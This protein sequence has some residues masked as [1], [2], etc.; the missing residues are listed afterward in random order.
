[1]E[2]LNPYRNEFASLFFS[3]LDGIIIIDTE[4]AK[5]TE[6]NNAALRILKY[7]R[8]ELV[9]NEYFKILVHEEQFNPEV[10]LENF[11]D[12]NYILNSHEFICQDGSSAFAD[13]SFSMIESNHKIFIVLTLRSATKRD[14]IGI[15]PL[16]DII[17]NGTDSKDC[18][19]TEAILKENECFHRLVG[20][21]NIMKDLFREIENISKFD[22]SILIYGETGTG[23]ELV[24]TAIHQQSKR[25]ENPFIIINC[26]GLSESL[27]SSQLFGHK[28]GSFTG[29]VNNQ[30]GLIEAAN[31]GTCF[32]DEIG[33]VPMA[34]QSHL[35]RVLQEKEI[36]MIGDSKSKKIDA[37][38]LAATNRDLKKE[39]DKDNFRLDLFYRIQTATI[40]VPPL[41]ERKEDI[42]Y[43]VAKF[44][45][46]FY[47]NQDK[48]EHRI[49]ND[50]IEA[51]QAHDWPGNV[52]ELKGSI[53]YALI[54]ANSQI[55]RAKDLPA[56][57]IQESAD[58]STKQMA[59]LNKKMSK[60]ENGSSMTSEDGFRQQ[61]MDALEKTNG[62]RAAAARLLG[63]G[64]TTL[65]RYLTNLK[66]EPKKP[67]NIF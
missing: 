29:A 16:S 37:R 61:I 23:K 33:D 39:V 36:V 8:E 38:F 46:D 12:D 28:K 7:K 43:L 25:S 11:S 62:N 59:E 13:L 58:N 4:S 44:L 30:Q 6:I 60:L 26:A 10:I 51:L 56:D 34:T 53:E 15:K 32:L 35:L 14:P 66:I 49:G 57:V 48:I 50:T 24:A 64:R 31:T 19:D 17:E 54:H 22:T 55:I 52:R 3:S 1:M 42:P 40:V 63:V 2:N 27:V 47:I 41:R 65:Y 9:G 5:I 45:Q 18:L 67:K 21:S 20:K